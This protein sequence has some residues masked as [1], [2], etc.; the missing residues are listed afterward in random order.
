MIAPRCSA[1]ATAFPSP[2]QAPHIVP[3][4]SLDLVLVPLV[5]FD[6]R[7]T[8]LGMGAGYYDRFFGSIARAL[9]PRIVGVAHEVQRSAAD[10][11]AAAWDVP[12]DGVLTERGWQPLPD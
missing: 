5:A 11:P 12:L 2:R 1:I 6:R 7:G 8:R 4:I 9:R 10:L 3:A